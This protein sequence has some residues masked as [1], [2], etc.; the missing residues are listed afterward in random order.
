MNRNVIMVSL[1]AAGGLV[2]AACHHTPPPARAVP[3]LAT[4]RQACE[5]DTLARR[6]KVLIDNL[7]VDSEVSE[8]VPEKIRDYRAEIDAAYR[9]VVENCNNYN[10]CMQAHRYHEDA[11]ADS[12]LAWAVSHSKFNEIAQ[13]LAEI[14]AWRRPPRK[15]H[16]RT[17]D[18]VFSTE[19]D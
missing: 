8:T 18:P 19:I 9:F 2:L 3:D 14:E 12:R 4:T 7:E 1:A 11:C 17:D 13:R 6:H 10:L 15:H 16:P 5:I